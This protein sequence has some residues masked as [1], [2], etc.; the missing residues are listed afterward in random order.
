MPKLNDKEQGQYKTLSLF[1]IK[2][3]LIKK[4]RKSVLTKALDPG[5]LSIAKEPLVCFDMRRIQKMKIYGYLRVST[6]HQQ[7][8]RQAQNILSRY[9]DAILYKEK[10]T[11][12]KID[13]PVWNKLY[14]LLKSEAAKGEDLTLIFD[15]ASRLARNAEEGFNI[16][17]ELFSLGIN[18]VFLKTPHI[19]SETYKRALENQVE[20]SALPDE[21]TNDLVQ[22]ITAAVNNY[23]MALAKKQIY[24]AFDSA[25]A[26]VNYLHQRVSEGVRLAQ[27]SG[28]QVGITKGTKLTTKKS[29]AAKQTIL[30]KSKF[31]N[32]SLNDKDLIAVL[33]ISANTYYKYKKELLEGAGE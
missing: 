18:L 28:K 24:L 4:Y 8:E 9:P 27:A 25:E 14:R 10:F 1:Y 17:Q 19:N 2:T 22:A 21:A 12:T 29:I 11:G 6:Q 23:I 20:V 5:I 33:G 15:E 16:Y 7:I 30:A 3:N 13:R 26:E 31:F 32:G